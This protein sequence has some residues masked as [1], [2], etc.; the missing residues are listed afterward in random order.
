MKQMLRASGANVTRTH[1]E[2]VSLCALFLMEAAKKADRAFHVT[3]QSTS[4][5]VRGAEGDITTMATHLLEQKATL[6]VPGR[7]TPLWVDPTDKGWEK[8]TQ[9]WLQTT[10]SRTQIDEELQEIRWRDGDEPVEL[11]YELHNV[12]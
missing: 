8:L 3:E 2:D 7:S 5:T 12:F 4:H 9:A 11:D 1:I 10:L 6:E